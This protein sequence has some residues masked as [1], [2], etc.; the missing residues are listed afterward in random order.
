MRAFP[1][2]TQQADRG[3]TYLNYRDELH[4]QLAEDLDWSILVTAIGDNIEEGGSLLGVQHFLGANFGG[5]FIH[6]PYLKY[7]RHSFIFTLPHGTNKSEV[8]RLG[9]EWGR[10]AQWT[11]QSWNAFEEGSYQPNRFK[12]RLEI[13]KFPLDFWHVPFIRHVMSQFG[14]VTSIDDEYIIG[15]DRKCLKLWISCIDPR[16]IPYKS[17]I[18]YD[19][20]WKECSIHII[21]WDYSGHF[22]EEAL[23]TAHEQRIMGV[24]WRNHPNWPRTSLLAA[25]D[26]LLN[27]FARGGY[28][29]PPD[30]PP[31]ESEQAYLAMTR[32]IQRGV[33]ETATRDPKL[34]IR[35]KTLVKV[36]QFTV[37]ETLSPEAKLPY[38][39]LPKGQHNRPTKEMVTVVVGQFSILQVEINRVHSDLEQNG[40]RHK[41]EQSKVATENELSNMHANAKQ[42]EE[43][44]TAQS[45]E[46]VDIKVGEIRI[47]HGQLKSCFNSTYMCTLKTEKGE[48]QNGKLVDDN[49]SL[50]KSSITIGDHLI[51]ID[52]IEDN[53]GVKAFNAE[54][55]QIKSQDPINSTIT[56]TNQKTPI[57]SPIKTQPLPFNLQHHTQDRPN[58]QH[59][60]TTTH[61]QKYY[62]IP[63]NRTEDSTISM[64]KSDDEFIAQFA[65][66]VARSEQNN[67]VLLPGQ[68][69]QE[70][71]WELCAIA[72]VVSERTTIPNQFSSTMKRAWAVHTDMTITSIA[73][74][75]YLVQFEKEQ[76]IN[77]VMHKGVWNYKGEI[78]VLKKSEGPV[79]LAQPKVPKMEVWTQLHNI[80]T[81]AF[82]DEGICMIAETLGETLSEPTETFLAGN[83]FYKIKILLPVDEP[84]KDTIEVTHQNLGILKIHVVYERLSKICLYCA[85]LG[86]EHI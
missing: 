43:G 46:L 29:T 28:Y 42:K 12:V 32:N 70:T 31:S 59:K 48:N 49:W 62:T 14:E 39:P 78:V 76:D 45:I 18:P 64:D 4:Q 77:R 72:R 50:S 1:M 57:Y 24:Q 51:W 7:T 19:T 2:T 56:T 37:L 81:Q 33:Q 36:G 17:Y 9:N 86:H 44:T 63:K 82:T 80:P 85:N 58:Q 55:G 68:A 22:P 8:V 67:P 15:N 26:K 53:R 25:H 69:M 38:L 60:L 40:M 34:A 79:D 5:N 41:L 27:F 47:I 35:D 10:T 61:L 54:T 75:Y 6:Y 3:C 65:A 66:L 11:F 71:K 52:S 16:R 30:S 73:K 23:L 74:N 83:K 84:L 20:I 13:L 21:S